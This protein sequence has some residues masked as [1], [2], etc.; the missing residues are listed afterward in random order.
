MISNQSSGLEFPS[1]QVD[2]GTFKYE[3]QRGDNTPVTPDPRNWY[4]VR[5][6][7]TTQPA[8]TPAPT[9]MPAATPEPN[10]VPTPTP[11]PNSSPAPIP[12][13]QPTPPGGEGQI[14][15][16]KPIDPIQA[17]TNTAN[18]AIG[19]FSSTI[20]LYYADMQTLIE[21][22]G[23]LRLGLQTTPAPTSLS[24]EQLDGG[25]GTVEPKQIASPPTV[26][27][28]SQWSI[29]IR[30]FGSGTRINNDVSRVFNQNVG[31]VQIGADRRLGSFWSGDVYLGLFA[32]YMYASRDFL[33]GGDGT[34][35]AFSLGAYA[36]WIHPQGW[37]ADT[38]LNTP[39]CGTPSIPRTWK[40]PSQPVTTI[41]RQLAVHWKSG[42]VSTLVADAFLWS[43]KLN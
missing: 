42:D 9:P 16:P 35:N 24:S 14:D 25:K 33:D 4:L 43:P 32:G 20:P 15:Y 11:V 22:M 8:A 13:P 23:E 10:P 31:G 5:D 39:K 26:P 12:T 19:S 30:G 40:V 3:S 18:A 36:T 38:V 41:S 27:L 21:R 7:Q 1:N 29:W 6:D 2:A 34:T 37:Y 17:L 28:S